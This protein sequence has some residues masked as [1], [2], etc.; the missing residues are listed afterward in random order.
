MARCA[1][2][3]RRRPART[4]RGHVAYVRVERIGK[5][6]IYKRGG[7][8][9]VYFRE[10]GQTVRQPID[11][12]LT[13][14]RATASKIN[15]ALMEQR[16]SPLG[17]RRTSPRQLLDQ[18]LD[19][20]TDVQGLALRTQDRYRAALTRFVEFCEQCEAASIDRVGEREIEEFVRWLRAKTRARNGSR[21][22]KQAP[23]QIGGIKFI[24]STCRTAFLWA[25]RQKMLPAYAANP[26]SNFRIDGLRSS[27]EE[28]T[29]PSLFTPEQEQAFF[30]ACDPWQ[31]PL[32][33]TLTTYGLRVGELTHLLIEDVDREAGAIH[34]RPKPEML[35][36]VKTRRKRSLPLTPETQ[37]IFEQL[38]GD[39]RA[40]FVFLN[41]EFV[42]GS[43]S[44]RSFASDKALRAHLRQIAADMRAEDPDLSDRVLLRTISRFCHSIG[45]VAERR[46]RSEFM[47][48]T[49][50]IGCPEMTRVHDLRHLFCSRAQEMGM[51]PLLVQKM[52][53]HAKLD[54]TA[55]YTHLGLGAARQ[56]MEQMLRPDLPNEV[57]TNGQEEEERA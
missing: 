55:R 36:T 37:P 18:Y 2:G 46:I 23:Y 20:I 34:V 10:Q 48:L 3:A 40:G 5:V 14:A 54:M 31:H 28:A 50:Q 38:I 24:L 39:R 51:N 1:D 52:L 45:Q 42:L 57:N 16:P 12:N 29:K 25:V 4:T 6:T 32:F 17:F 41:K 13:T 22:G 44:A 47:M 56:A 15:A 8:Y 11:G 9:S 30:K 7:R 35:W 33:F 26:F 53:G 21:V 43:R 19:F 49:E 27:V